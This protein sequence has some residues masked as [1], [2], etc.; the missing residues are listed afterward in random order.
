MKDTDSD[1]DNIPFATRLAGKTMDMTPD[2][3]PDPMVTLTAVDG[4]AR[5]TIRAFHSDARP[6]NS[7]ADDKL[8]S[9]RRLQVNFDGACRGNGQ[10]KATSKNSE[11]AIGVV[12]TDPE[13]GKWIT[14]WGAKLVAD[15]FHVGVKQFT[16]AGNNRAEMIALVEAL[17]ASVALKK[18][19]AEFVEL[20]L[21]GDS[22]FAVP[23]FGKVYD[24]K[25]PVFVS[26]RGIVDSL[27]QELKELGVEVDTHRV[28]RRWNACADECCNAALD[29]RPLNQLIET[30]PLHELPS[31]AS[32]DPFKILAHARDNRFRCWRSLP[33]EVKEQFLAATELLLADARAAGQPPEVWLALAPSI[34]LRTSQQTQ[35]RLNALKRVLLMAQASRLGRVSLVMSLQQL[36]EPRVLNAYPEVGPAKPPKP[37]T[38]ESRVHGHLAA[39]SPAKA[40]KEADLETFAA[41]RDEVL[42]AAI[43]TY[44]PWSLR[45]EQ[46][47]ELPLPLPLEPGCEMV[48]TADEIH[49]VLVKTGMNKS[50]GK[51]GW[52]KELLMGFHVRPLLNEFVCSTMNGIINDS[53]DSRLLDFLYSATMIGFKQ[54]QNIIGAPA[55][56]RSAGLPTLFTKTAWKAALAQCPM[57]ELY[58]KMQM[59]GKKD[60]AVNTARFAQDQLDRGKAVIIGDAVNAHPTFSRHVL[61]QFMMK[62][63]AKLGPLFR[64]WNGT[65]AKARRLIIYDEKTGKKSNE[66]FLTTGD[67]QGATSATPGF[68]CT[69]FHCIEDYEEDFD[70]NCRFLADDTTISGDSDAIAEAR[71]IML[72]E[73]LAIADIDIRGPKKKMIGVDNHEPAVVAGAVVARSTDRIPKDGK[74]LKPIDRFT[75][76]V[77]FIVGLTKLKHQDTLLLTSHVSN[78]LKYFCSA[79]KPEITSLFAKDLKELLELPL[80]R[81]LQCDRLPP[82]ASSQIYVSTSSAGLGMADPTLCELIY[83]D[84]GTKLLAGEESLYE[85]ESRQRWEIRDPR[86]S[87]TAGDRPGGQWIT[88]IK[89]LNMKFAWWRSVYPTERSLEIS[90]EAVT[91]ALSMHLNVNPQPAHC[92]R[93]EKSGSNPVAETTNWADHEQVCTYCS[94]AWRYQRHQAALHQMCR[95]G[96]EMAVLIRRQM[97]DLL[98]T[99]ENRMADEDATDAA[100]GNAKAEDSKKRPDGFI[101]IPL[102][103]PDVAAHAK[104][105]MFDLTIV[106]FLSTP[107]QHNK[108]QGCAIG[109]RKSSKKGKYKDLLFTV[110]HSGTAGEKQWLMDS[111][112][113]PLIFSATGLPERD[114]V[115]TMQEMGKTAI[116]PGFARCAIMRMQAALLNAAALGISLTRHRI[117]KMQ[118]AGIDTRYVKPTDGDDEEHET[119]DHDEDDADEDRDDGNDDGTSGFL[120]PPMPP[121]GLG[122]ARRWAD[123]A[124]DGRGRGEGR[125]GGGEAAAEENEKQKENKEKG[126]PKK[127]DEKE[128]KNNNKN[129]TKTKKETE[130]QKQKQQQQVAPYERSVRAVNSASDELNKNFIACVY[131]C[132]SIDSRRCLVWSPAPGRLAD[133]EAVFAALDSQPGATRGFGTETCGGAAGRQPAAATTPP[134]ATSRGT[135]DARHGGKR[136]DFEGLARTI[137]FAEDVTAKDNDPGDRENVVVNR[138]RTRRSETM[139]GT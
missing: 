81:I 16:T 48:V 8:F 122:G 43:R 20:A 79:T 61:R 110:E 85:R 98:G 101:T 45:K 78:T 62:H 86:I 33:R 15:G 55:K 76:R 126:E 105:V 64:L 54:E 92:V 30:P 9:K 19:R 82:S 129:K 103:G 87:R 72:A 93:P 65:Y 102:R 80:L 100:D 57:Q 84:T 39:R 28:D 6:R 68:N 108:F 53:L 42:E 95:T 4:S 31:L 44:A 83:K 67:L 27:I 116:L 119:S 117:A 132:F 96:N 46:Q 114:C 125:G 32:F 37:E 23:M 71:F 36:E 118:A 136:E 14:A 12:F 11:S 91:I 7:S 131:P 97:S 52:T 24:Y 112:I 75:R 74:G 58:G 3:F 88:N 94:S 99:I 13:T 69:L 21:V 38:R 1:D 107:H 134:E 60:G 59:M 130:K 22:D 77:N 133:T 115:K 10:R 56:T 25:E 137:F 106:A 90:D 29:G 113:A 2:E 128:K 70:G 50:P 111:E 121:P 51:D 49:L 124:D 18:N 66:I 17:S 104:L 120:Q 89:Q 138:R 35:R 135:P 123:V 26:L 34:F 127:K 5:P 63:K 139:Q 73:A 40:M 47:P 109:L 41:T